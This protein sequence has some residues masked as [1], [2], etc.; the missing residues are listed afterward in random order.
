MAKRQNQ[1]YLVFARKRQI[2]RYSRFGTSHLQVVNSLASKTSNA[3][4]LT[5]SYQGPQNRGF[6]C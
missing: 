1:G 6:S 3:L 4:S 2:L 5:L